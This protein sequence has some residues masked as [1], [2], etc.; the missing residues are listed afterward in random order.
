MV[1]ADLRRILS[2][3]WER[4][5][6]LRKSSQAYRIFHGP[7]EG[8]GWL[9]RIAI[10]RFAES[11]WITDWESAPA[12]GLKTIAEFL[13]ERGAHAAVVQTREA[14]GEGRLGLP[15][16]LAGEARGAAGGS[17]VLKFWVQ[18]AG[19]KHPGLFLDHA[20]LR[21]W[22]VQHARGLR[23]LNLFATRAV[24]RWPAGWVELSGCD[25]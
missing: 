18:V 20:R 25:A 3:A 2:G 23:V 21:E 7:G 16:C 12:A 13:L 22:L 19:V 14:K 9:A 8:A 5:E 15:R 10:D 4:R 17:G 1:Q 6:S 24:C 11:Y